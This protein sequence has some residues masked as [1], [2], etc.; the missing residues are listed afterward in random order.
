MP[1][2]RY[3]CHAFIAFC[4]LVTYFYWHGKN[5]AR[6]LVLVYSAMQIGGLWL[7]K[8]HDYGYADTAVMLAQAL[9]GAFLL[10]WLNTAVVRQFFERQG[11]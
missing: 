3:L 6:I 8:L 10:Y 4:L 2:L 5:W 9:F 1:W 11:N 7:L